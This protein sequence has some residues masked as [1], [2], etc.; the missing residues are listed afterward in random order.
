MKM[1]SL[2]FSSAQRSVAALGG[3]AAGVAEVVEAGPGHAMKPFAMVEAAL[4]QAGIEREQIERVVVGLGP[5]S[6]T[7]IRAAIA[8]AQGWQLATGAGLLGVSSADG[9]AARAQAEGIAGRCSVVIDAQRGEFYVAGYEL[10][11]GGPREITPLRIATLAEMRD[12]EATGELL[13]GPEVTRWF[14]NGRVTFPGA[15]M[16]GQLARGKADLTPGGQLE[17]IYLRTTSF[18]KAPPA[19]TS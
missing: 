14:P 12:L 7:G 8:L 3:P 13:A 15:A 1:L 6:Y 2:E 16:L 18:V 4:R 10:G 5:G 9:V 17:P 11:D 19:R